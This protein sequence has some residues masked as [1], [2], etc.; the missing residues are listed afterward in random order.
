[1]PP[2]RPAP[3]ALRQRPA[4]GDRHALQPAATSMQ[5][6]AQLDTPIAQAFA[7]VAVAAIEQAGPSDLIASHGRTL[8]HCT[9]GGIEGGV[10]KGTLQ[11][12]QAA[13]I[14]EHTWVP[15]VS[16]FRK[17]DV[18][19]GGPPATLTRPTAPEACTSPDLPASRRSPHAQPRCRS[20]TP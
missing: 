6:V 3:R 7:E 8:Y 9:E 12:G 19:A 16:D 18:A 13:W 10:V 20:S 11:L 15:V 2:T 4:P 5:A 1:M 17:R 14:A